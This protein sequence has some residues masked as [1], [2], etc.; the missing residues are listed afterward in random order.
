MVGDDNR[1]APGPLPVRGSPEPG[2]REEIRRPGSCP[3]WGDS[4]ILDLS[5][6]DV[7]GNIQAR[8]KEPL[9]RR[10]DGSRQAH[11][12]QVQR[13]AGPA[14][15][16]DKEGNE[17]DPD[18]G[19]QVDPARGAAVSL[20]RGRLAFWRFDPYGDNQLI[21]KLIFWVLDSR[22]MK[23]VTTTAACTN[24]AKDTFRPIKNRIIEKYER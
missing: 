16:E 11:E 1:A 7:G 4:E 21:K 10:P 5:D 6:D 8:I 18:G 17:K 12:I 2:R 3:E 19:D 13:S 24:G 9:G 22:G 23:G 15:P 20:G 14:A